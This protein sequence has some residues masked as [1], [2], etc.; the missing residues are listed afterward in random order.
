MVETLYWGLRFGE[1][2]SLVGLFLGP[3]VAVLVTLYIEG[4]RRTRDQHIQIMRML[5]STR[6]LAGDPLYSVAI[7]LIP[8]E[9]NDSK[10]I[11]AAWRTYIEA[12]RFK[13][14]EDNAEEH[15]RLLL[16]KQTKLIFELLKHLKF[17]L[18]ETD[19]QTSAYAADAFIQRDNILLGSQIAMADIANSLRRQT[20]FL[21]GVP[22]Q[23]V[24][25]AEARPPAKRKKAEG[26]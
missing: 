2:V 10:P 18:P 1:W 19:I 20:D 14:T 7:N 11:M 17:D 25:R 3:I 23:P 8:I 26:S 12:V 4:R 15:N 21:Q 6:H 5:L 13:P 9:F 16:S 22:Q 24:E